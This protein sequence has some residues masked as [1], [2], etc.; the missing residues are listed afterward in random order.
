MDELAKPWY[1]R[2]S[3]SAAVIGTVDQP[4]RRPAEQITASV[5]LWLNW[6]AF[7]RWSPSDKPVA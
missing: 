6:L 5:A 3:F 1:A 7:L 4:L 2:S